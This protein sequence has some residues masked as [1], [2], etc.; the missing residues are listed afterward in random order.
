MKICITRKLLSSE[1]SGCLIE[2]PECNYAIRFGFSYLCCHPDHTR[3]R[4]DVL[5]VLTNDEINEL[6]DLL[7][8]KRRDELLANLDGQSRE[9]FYR[10]A[11]FSQNPSPADS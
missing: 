2:K 4:A 9:G 7:R 11:D 8:Q 1:I 3:F 6:Y 5:G 10:S